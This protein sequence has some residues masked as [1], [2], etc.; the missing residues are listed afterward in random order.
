MYNVLLPMKFMNGRPKIWQTNVSFTVLK[1][2]QLCSL[3]RNKY[4][5]LQIVQSLKS[6]LDL[7]TRIFPGVRSP[8]KLQNANQN[9]QY[10]LWT[11]LH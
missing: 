4:F 8:T 1:T 6:Y 9:R 7:F 11:L 10:C 3:I 2:T 5:F